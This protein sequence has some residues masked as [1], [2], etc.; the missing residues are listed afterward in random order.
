MKK[1]ASIFFA[2]SFAIV[3]LCLSEGCSKATS[4]PLTAC[5]DALP[6]TISAGG[7]LTFISCTAGVTSYVWN[8][9]D[10]G[11]ATGD[12]VVYTYNTPG[13]YTGSLTVSYG[14]TSSVQKFTITVVPNSWTFNEVTYSID[15]V[16]GSR[17]G[18]T[19]SATGTSG[20]K[21][22][23]LTFKFYPYPTVSGYYTVVDGQ[24]GATRPYQMLVTFSNDSAG[25]QNIFVST[26]GGSVAATV[27]VSN[28]LINIYLPAIGMMNTNN[29]ADSLSLSASIAQ[30]H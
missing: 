12:S 16:V 22:A 26:G 4:S 15:S 2:L 8:F 10:G 7:S 20:N 25:T 18:A 27:T 28:G 29:P 14:N 30:T 24:Y 19:L 21:N 1:T 6:G 23:N 9:G 13:T 11:T 17:L 3:C 5:I